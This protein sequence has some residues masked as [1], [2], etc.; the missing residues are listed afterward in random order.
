ME[1]YFWMLIGALVLGFFVSTY[2]DVY[3]AWRF[4]RDHA[5]VVQADEL[6][7][8]PAVAAVSPLKQALR[9]AMDRGDRFLH[10]FL[11]SPTHR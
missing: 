5:P 1:M 3:V 9:W 2:W 11:M 6:V 7:S 10:A 4:Y 8:P